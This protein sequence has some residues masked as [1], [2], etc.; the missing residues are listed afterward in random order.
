LT[1]IAGKPLGKVL[2][3]V[4]FNLLM[5][6]IVFELCSIAET[7]QINII[8]KDIIEQI[9]LLPKRLTTSMQRD[10]QSGKESEIE[11]ILGN[12][13]KIGKAAG[14]NLPYLEQCYSILVKRCKF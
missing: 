10:I 8:A 12:P 1:S 5:K 7:Q 14:I 2:E 3:N 13:I 4:E 6:N 11:A 9:E